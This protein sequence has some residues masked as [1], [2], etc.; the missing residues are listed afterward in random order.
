MVM[1]KYIVLLFLG[2]LITANAQYMLD[3]DGTLADQANWCW[4]A[5]SQAVLA[6][7]GTYK[8]Q[9]EIA[10]YVRTSG[11]TF[12]YYGTIPC[13]AD[14]TWG[15]T[16]GAPLNGGRGSVQD[17]LCELGNIRSVAVLPLSKQEIVDQL[18]QNKPFVIGWE[19]K[20]DPSQGHVM[21]GCGIIGDRI[22]FVDPDKKPNGYNDLPYDELRENDEY[23]WYG[24]L[25]TIN[26]SRG[27]PCCCNNGEWDADKGELGVDCGG[28][29]PK[30]C[31][32]PP[33][34]HCNNRIKDGDETGIDCGGVN[35][36]PCT[37]CNNCTLDPGEDAIDCGGSCTPCKY[38]G[39]VTDQLNITTT[40]Q[41]RWE[42]MAFK[43]ITAG[44]AT[45][46]AS[47]QE[48]NFITKK[49]G[50]IVLLS[51]FTAKNGSTFRTQMKDLT[52]YERLCGAICHDHTLSSTHKAFFD[53]LQIKNLL[54][55][56]R[57]GYSIYKRDGYAPDPIYTR[58]FDIKRN[59]DFPL[60][61]CVTGAGDGLIGT[62][63]YYIKYGIEY[64][65][66]T[67]YNSTHN[68]SVDYS[69]YKSSTKES[70]EP[71][72]LDTHQSSSSDNLKIHDKM[73]APSLSIIPNPN[74][75]TFHLETNFPLSEIGNLK[76]SSLMGATVYESQNVTEHTIQLQ[77]SASGMFFVVIILKDGSVLTQKMMVQR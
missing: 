6:Y 49:T 74:P 46:V 54:Y 35:C 43:K 68:F 8:D 56:V 24:T 12:H 58:N 22:Y 39:G 32:T 10:E 20:A 37:P 40:A 14:P 34:D 3:V 59:G 36:P 27:V 66:G 62:V 25:T 50:S 23:R 69:Y 21:V 38:I 2:M 18:G 67:Y 73:S 55:A 4:A 9:C 41:L 75:G 26:P 77:N 17:I 52:E 44:G 16:Q 64:C 76:I 47:G 72:N 11:T 53:Y 29:C 51:G 42:M 63:R 57:I 5:S 45:T 33:L 31:S 48:V 65:N 60:W 28:P 61:D 70:D 71:E 19:L 30:N 1:K 15:C 7:Y 13:C